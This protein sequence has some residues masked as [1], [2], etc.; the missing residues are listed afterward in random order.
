MTIVND[1]APNA[2]KTIAVALTDTQ[3][4]SV[5]FGGQAIP[6]DVPLA[7]IQ[8]EPNNNVFGLFSFAGLPYRSYSESSPNL[9]INVLRTDSSIGLHRIVLY[10]RRRL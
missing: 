7:I 4:S 2:G 9:L 8:I 6:I 3:P 1:P 10:T 5:P